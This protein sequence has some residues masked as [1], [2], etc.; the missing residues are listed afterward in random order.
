MAGPAEGNCKNVFS[1][2]GQ[3][4]D[5]LTTVHFDEMNSA[6]FG[7]DRNYG[8]ARL[9]GWPRGSVFDGIQFGQEVQFSGGQIPDT[10]A[11]ALVRP[12]VIA[13]HG[14]DFLTIGVEN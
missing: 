4:G 2:C 12:T 14:R 6:G 8:L 10:D 3:S 1:D 9:E 13:G 11:N 5:L 7:A